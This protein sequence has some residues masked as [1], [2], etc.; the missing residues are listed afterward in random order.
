[1]NAILQTIIAIVIVAV[2]ALILAHRA[3]NFFTGTKT[4]GCGSCA[5]GSCGA[6]DCSSEAAPQGPGELPIVSLDEI[7]Q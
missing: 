1:M 5:S 4:P 2:A 3:W 7:R 6:T